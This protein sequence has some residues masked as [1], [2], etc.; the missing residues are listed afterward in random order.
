[1]RLALDMTDAHHPTVARLPRD[2]D[3][4]G[5]IAAGHK[6]RAVRLHAHAADG[7]AGEPCALLGHRLEA[8]HRHGFG[9]RSAVY[10][11]ELRQHVLDSVLIDDALRFS[12][13]HESSLLEKGMAM[14]CWQ[15][16]KGTATSDDH[17]NSRHA[18]CSGERM[19]GLEVGHGYQNSNQES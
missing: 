10:I 14:G 18:D 16:N 13:Q 4:R 3:Q 17:R 5:E 6:V 7:K 11:D 2:R 8:G 19:G 12:W 15:A 9:L 1:M